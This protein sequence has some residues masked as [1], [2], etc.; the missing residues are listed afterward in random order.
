M[1]EARLVKQ[2][3]PRRDSAAFTLDLELL[4]ADGVTALFG[5]SGSGKTLTLDCIAGFT[6]PDSGRI[7]IDDNIVFDGPARVHLSPQKRRC[8]YVFQNYALFPHMTVRG[9]IEFAAEGWKRTERKRRVSEMLARFRLEDVAGRRPHEI[10][11][12][13]KQRCSVARALMSDPG[14]LLLDEPA[15]GM[16]SLLKAE[17]YDILRQVRADFGTPTLLV[18][19]NLEECFHLADDMIVLDR[20]RAVQCGPPADVC[21]HPANIELARLFGRDNVLPVEIRTLD[22]SRNTSTVRWGEWDIHGEYIPAHLI[23]DHVH[24][25][26][27]P[28][29]MRALP[30]SGTP[31][32][33]QAALKLERSVETS[34][35]VQLEFAG[36]IRA[37]TPRNEFAGHN[38]DWVVEFPS[39]GLR[40]L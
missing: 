7:L 32:P 31:G 35:S 2:F 28:R 9:N 11:G 34:D 22:P 29:E 30:H 18:T 13:Q 16:D 20:G 38:G 3:Q 15:T 17:F 36:G 5:P 1:I 21:A 8:G 10:S 25:L 26:V 27:G 23:G 14:V 39:K 4:A 40:V 19:H 33:N 24:L 37:E 6:R 12:G